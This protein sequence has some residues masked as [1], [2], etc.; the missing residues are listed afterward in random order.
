MIMALC[1]LVYNLAHRQLRLAL[2]LAQD[3]I[4]NQLGKS[5]NSPTLRWVYQCFMEVHLVSF[6]GV[7]LIVN[8]SDLRFRI[9]NF[10]SPACQR[11]YRLLYK[12]LTL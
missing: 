12:K 8:L 4:S 10:F 1:L 3:T 5:T 6:Q 9:L 2:A 7:I 11:Y